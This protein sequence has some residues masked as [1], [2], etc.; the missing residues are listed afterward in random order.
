MMPVSP[1]PPIVAAN[2]S[3]PS[4]GM[5][6]SISSLIG[7][8]QAQLPD[9]A[10]EAAGGDD[11][12]C[13]ARRWPPGAPSVAWRAPG[14]VVVNHPGND[15]AQEIAES[16]ARLRLHDAPCQIEGD[17]AIQPRHVDQTL[18]TVRG[19][20]RHRS[21]RE[22]TASSERSSD[23]ASRPFNSSRK[24]KAAT[25]WWTRSTRPHERNWSFPEKPVTRTRHHERAGDEQ[26]QHVA[27]G[28][29]TA[30]QHRIVVELAAVGQQPC[31]RTRERPRP[32]SAIA[33]EDGHRGS[34]SR[35]RW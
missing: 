33:S 11:G 10:A 28:S 23:S 31:G 35:H 8:Q 15:V 16:E 3:P 27:P 19:N 14:V 9:A 12:S 30:E 1:R 6:R 29:R 4:P 32:R 5:R 13:R 24:A 34:S 25:S 2:R 26:P 18:A 17:Q 21:G 20:Y 22:P 7:A